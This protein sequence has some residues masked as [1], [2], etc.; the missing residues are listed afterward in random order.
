MISPAQ[1]PDLTPKQR[2]SIRDE[3]A[4]I[5]AC[6]SFSGSKRCSDFLEYVVKYSLSGEYERLTERFLG[7]ELFGRPVDYETATDSVVRVRATDV[8]RRLAQHYA[9]HS[10]NAGVAIKLAPGSYIAEFHWIVEKAED[11][12]EVIPAV[13]FVATPQQLSLITNRFGSRIGKEWLIGVVTLLIVGIAATLYWHHSPSASNSALNR[14]WQPIAGNRNDV[15][16]LFGNTVSYWPTRET[17]EAMKA[18]GQTSGAM[19]GLLFKRSDD[20][21]TEGNIRAAFSITNLLDRIGVN[22][23]L[24]WP[25]ET[26]QSDLAGANVVYI[27]AFNNPWTMTLN[28][29]LRFS[30]AVVNT[31]S[32]TTWMIRDNK[33]PKQNWSVSAIYPEPIT[34][35]FALITRIFDPNQNCVEVSIGG[36]NMFGTQAAGEF[37]TNEASM[38]SFARTAPKGWEKKNIQIVLAMEVSEGRV[39]KPKI[40]A[41]EVW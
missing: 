25:K 15:M 2:A 34:D 26:Q 6:N 31:S 10:S 27:G 3:L 17:I 12:A 39:V 33:D 22:T 37:L 24:R 21:A 32:Q 4:E 9:E 19:A 14:F 20:E 18:R 16:I 29:N 41:T 40:V 8:R 35:D 28:Q 30:F 13:S 7:A 23:Q 11:V 36:L 38:A 5:L 1:I